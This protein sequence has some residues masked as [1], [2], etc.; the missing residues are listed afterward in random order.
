M[1]VFTLIVTQLIAGEPLS[2][3]DFTNQLVILGSF[4]FLNFSFTSYYRDLIPFIFALGKIGT[5]GL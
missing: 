2:F 1:K 4:I 5:K 3:R